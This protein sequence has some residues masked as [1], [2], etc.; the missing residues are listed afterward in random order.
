MND[1][2]NNPFYCLFEWMESLCPDDEMVGMTF[3]YFEFML[4]KI[5]LMITLVGKMCK[6]FHNCK[7]LYSKNTK[8]AVRDCHVILAKA[9]IHCI[10]LKCDNSK[11]TH[12]KVILCQSCI[13]FQCLAQNK[14]CCMP[15]NAQFVEYFMQRCLS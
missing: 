8:S 7:L 9:G 11:C 12:F 2:L 14:F 4:K 6:M 15:K 13:F 5:L 1:E 3:A 10:I